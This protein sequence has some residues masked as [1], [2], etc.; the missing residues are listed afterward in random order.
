MRRILVTG[1]TGYLGGYACTRLL[2]IDPDVHLDLFV[3]ARDPDHAVRKLWK[4]WQLHLDPP[5][6]RAALERVRF[7]PGD[8]HAT[9]L[10][11]A[12]EDRARLVEG[13]DSVL[14]VAASLNR[15]SERACLNTNVRGLLSVLRLARAMADGGGLRRFS[16]V[17]TAAVAGE[18]WREVV[19]EDQAIDWWNRQYDPYARTK[20]LG[21]HMVHELLFDVDRLVFRPSSVMGD[22]RRPETTQWD[23]VRAYVFFADLPALPWGPDIRQDIVPADFVGD[24]IATLHLRE[25]CRHHTYHLTAGTGSATTADIMRALL[26]ESGRRP[27]AF[28]T[29]MTGPF[30]GGVQAVE[31]LAPGRTT[32]R[33]AALLRVFL[34]Y[35]TND[36]VFD[37]GRIVAELGRAP[38][39]FPRYA[40]RLYRY[41]RQV[42]FRYP[43]A[44]WPPGDGAQ[45]G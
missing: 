14:H 35:V 32:Q 23:M 24:A 22:S 1:G 37:N 30:Q 45:A 27:P 34:P 16:F 8:L 17:S 28:L 12:E 6:F 11:L 13:T 4:G 38:T 29:R 31:A 19:P 42:D 5:A 44:P 33:M 9:G 20:A 40:A 10:G 21:E 3:R 26:A 2:D 36:T 15:N 43:H 25:R 39:P 7:V 18:R 41:A